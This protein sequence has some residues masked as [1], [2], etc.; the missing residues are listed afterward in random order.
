MIFFVLKKVGLCLVFFLYTALK[1]W[2]GGGE[3][4]DYTYYSFKNG[5]IVIHT[6]LGRLIVYYTKFLYILEQRN[7]GRVQPVGVQTVM[8]EIKF[9]STF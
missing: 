7:I 3:F 8:V 6:V 9:R 4:L 5:T 1:K 2:T